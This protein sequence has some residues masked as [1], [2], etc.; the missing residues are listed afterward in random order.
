M[1]GEKNKRGKSE[2]MK[3]S[4]YQLALSVSHNSSAALMCDGK[5]IVAVCEERFYREKNYVGYPKRS[6]DYCLEKAGITGEQL[7]R[8]A[9]TTVDNPGLLIKAKTTAKF[10]LRDYRDYYGHKYY[11]RKFNGENCFDYWRWACRL[12]DGAS[13]DAAGGVGHHP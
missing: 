9:Y 1:S 6:I 2:R 8:V 10:S 12:R 11:K 7:S 3:K 13:T 4:I 5:I